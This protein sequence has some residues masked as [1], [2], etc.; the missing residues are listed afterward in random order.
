MLNGNSLQDAPWAREE[1]TRHARRPD[2]GGPFPR[3]PTRRARFHF[4][5]SF[6]A[7]GWQLVYLGFL[8][9][10]PVNSI[11][12]PLIVIGGLHY[13]TSR[14]RILPEGWR[15]THIVPQQKMGEIQR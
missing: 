5:V 9:P 10:S 14:L 6:D 8:V 4:I 7:F 1:W 11:Q 2:A 12:A 15:V 13:T 3:L